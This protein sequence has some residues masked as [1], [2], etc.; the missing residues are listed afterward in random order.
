MSS[1]VR[2]AYFEKTKKARLVKIQ[3]P[4]FLETD[5]FSEMSSLT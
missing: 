1:P 5:S 3:M 4:K 2:V